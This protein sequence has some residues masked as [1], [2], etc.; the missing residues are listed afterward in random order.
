MIRDVS[1]QY[2]DMKYSLL[3]DQHTQAGGPRSELGF[4]GIWWT[5]EKIRPEEI[6]CIILNS[7]AEIR[8]SPTT[9]AVNVLMM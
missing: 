8:I 2:Q 9:I 6:S 4:K 7:I 5:N 1:S 3:K